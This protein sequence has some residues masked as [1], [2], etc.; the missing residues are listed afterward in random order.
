MKN[1]DIINRYNV[2]SVIQLV[3][4]NNESL[5]SPL[6][7]K[8]ISERIKSGK[9]VDS[10]KDDIQKFVNDLITDE[11]KELA[12]KQDKTEED[13]AKLMN[14]EN[15]LQE[16]QKMYIYNREQEEAV[17][18]EEFY[19]TEDEY[20]QIVSVNSKDVVINGQEVKLADFLEYLYKE[21]VK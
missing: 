19:F 2:L 15:D 17:D 21:F 13:F 16:Q 14:Y 10:I 1:R 18:F 3:N 9:L 8:I 5:D 12:N 6:K 11:M 7:V 4:N 20:Y